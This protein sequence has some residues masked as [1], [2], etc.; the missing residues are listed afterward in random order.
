MMRKTFNIWLFIYLGFTINLVYCEKI[1]N[2]K[3][4]S[5]FLSQYVPGQLI[6]NILVSMLVD[7]WNSGNFSYS[8]HF[9]YPIL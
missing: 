3:G 8:F 1:S 9:R 4:S 7:L 5:I 2:T 6:Q